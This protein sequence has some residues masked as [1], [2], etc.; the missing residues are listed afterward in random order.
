[1]DLAC[2]LLTLPDLVIGHQSE[3]SLDIAKVIMH[4]NA[5]KVPTPQL[6]Y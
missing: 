1:M 5:L 4:V 3:G 2:L 6:Y